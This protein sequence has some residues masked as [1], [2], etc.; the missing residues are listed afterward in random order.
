MQKSLFIGWYNEQK[1]DK[2]Q[3]ER[4][5]NRYNNPFELF[6]PST[7][8]LITQLFF[9]DVFLL[10]NH[11]TYSIFLRKQAVLDFESSS[12]PKKFYCSIK[13]D[14]PDGPGQVPPYSGVRTMLADSATMFSAYNGI[15]I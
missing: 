14:E 10:P 11:N 15:S 4:G 1:I 13:P 6:R 5:S 2:W 3:V 9:V 7:E 8:L 12:N